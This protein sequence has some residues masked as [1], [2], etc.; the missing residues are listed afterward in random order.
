[1][2][3]GNQNVSLGYQR[4]L[5]SSE[6]QVLSKLYL[7]PYV[8]GRCVVSEHPES[9]ALGPPLHEDFISIFP[10]DHVSGLLGRAIL[11][12]LGTWDD[13]TSQRSTVFLNLL[14]IGFNGIRDH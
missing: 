3:T 4:G 11:S 9:T 14:P 6:V 5:T 8:A 1:M 7:P 2:N 13:G 10:W 12:Q